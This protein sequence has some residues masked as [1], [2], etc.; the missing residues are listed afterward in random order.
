MLKKVEF[1]FVLGF[2]LRIAFTL[3]GIY[4]D[5]YAEQANIRSPGANNSSSRD[6][7]VIPKYTDVDYLVFTD[8]AEY[9]T[10]GESPYLRDTYRYT[11]LLAFFLQ[12]NLLVNESFGK[13]IFVTLDMVCAFL[14]LKING[15]NKSTTTNKDG[16]LQ[17]IC[18]WFYNPITIAISSRGNAESIMSTLVLAFVYYFKKESYFVAGALYALSI[19]FKIYPLAYGL[20]LLVVFVR[21]SLVDTRGQYLD[22]NAAKIFRNLSRVILNPNLFKFGI[23][24]QLVIVSSTLY[25]YYSYGY[26]FLFET[27]IY[28]LGRQDIRHNFSPYFYMLYLSESE[29]AMP[30]QLQLLLKF[31]NFFL[32]AFLISCISI[33]YWQHLELAL[34]MITY[35]FVTFNKVC[36]S[37]YFVWYLCLIPLILP[38]TKV[39]I[40]SLFYLLLW[41]VGQSIW[42]YFG[43]ELE[44]NG[45]NVFIQLWIAGLLFASINCYIIKSAFLDKYDLKYSSLFFRDSTTASKTKKTN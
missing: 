39:S 7:S 26:I 5:N 27:Y 16:N 10:K 37:Q 11:P 28:H 14:I 43:Y 8:A 30:P 33:W 35:I 18:F 34:F 22:L 6:N 19:H 13:L 4:H 1:H 31:F 42:L 24:F 9:M 2:L 32:Q 23:A 17:G 44:F 36:T 25:F 15:A 40:S 45:K 3:Y 21:S 29:S 20:I 41:F 38:R 12:P